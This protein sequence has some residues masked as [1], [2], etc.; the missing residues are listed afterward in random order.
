[1]KGS[2]LLG[3][4]YEPLFNFAKKKLDSDHDW[5][6]QLDDYVSDD[7]GTGLVHLACFG[8]DDVRIFQRENIPVFDPVDDEG[9]FLDY[10]GFIAGK[11]IKD[12]DKPIV[13][14]LKEEGK[15]FL[16]E[17][18]QHSY[19]FCWRTDT[20]LIYKPISTWFVNVEAIKE[21]MHAH[22]KTVH[23]VP[24]HIRDGRFGK[25]LEMPATGP[26]VVTDSGG[27]L[28]LS[29]KAKKGMCCV[30]AVL[31]NWKN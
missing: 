23:W 2:E 9:N 30:L 7:S 13:Q 24:G 12:A 18:I 14:R 27:L 19:P 3:M 26:S 17:T 16:H 10:M 28:F 20:P 31:R 25:W 21:K 29:G 8:E 6:V 4:K 22:N 15:M 11:N 1:M 5:S